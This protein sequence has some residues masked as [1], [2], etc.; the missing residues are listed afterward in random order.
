[1]KN[2]ALALAALA[3]LG[4]TMPAF[5]YDDMYNA[6]VRNGSIDIN[7]NGRASTTTLPR[8]DEGK[9]VYTLYRCNA[10]V[11]QFGSE[12]VALKGKAYHRPSEGDTIKLMGNNSALFE[13]REGKKTADAKIIR[14]GNENEVYGA[15]RAQCN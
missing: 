5:A 9:V 8:T 6:P 4:T 10:F 14:R 11:A 13:S 15:A 3:L 1:M 2:T 12:Y 7:S